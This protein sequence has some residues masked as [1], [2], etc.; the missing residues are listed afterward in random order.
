MVEIAK[1]GELRQRLGAEARRYIFSEHD[2][3]KIGEQML[4]VYQEMGEA[5]TERNKGHE[6]TRSVKHPEAVE[7]RE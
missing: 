3:E 4:E 5:F 2:W 7:V 1:N 6:G